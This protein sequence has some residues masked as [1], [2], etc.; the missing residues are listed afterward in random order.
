MRRFVTLAAAAALSAV[1]AACSSSSPGSGSPSGSGSAPGSGSASGSGSPATSGFTATTGTPA[2]D[3]TQLN[4]ALPGSEPAS[5]DWI[6]DWDYGPANT[7]EANLCEGLM[8]QNPDG[9]VTPALASKVESPNPTTYV[10][11]IRQGVTFT[12][13]KPMTAAD[14][15][16]SL[17]RN[18]T[19]SPPSYWGLW[20]A[21]VKSI[22]ATSSDTVTV[23]LK[24]PD[25][26][27]SEM[28]STPAGYVGEKAYIQAK[29]SAYGTSAG[30]VMCTGPYSLKNWSKGQS[31]TLARNDHYW[32]PSLQPKAATVVMSFIPDPSALNS[33]LLNGEVSGASGITVSSLAALR[34]TGSGH[35]Y[36][37]QGTETVVMQFANLTSGPLKDVRVREALRDVVDYAGI[38]KGLM[39]GYAEPAKSSTPAPTWGYAKAVFKAG[40]A[41]LAGG[42]QNLDEAKTLLQQAGAPTEP[43]VIALNSDD[44]SIINAVTAIQQAAGT[45]GLKITLKTMP[46]QEFTNLFYDAKARAAVN[47]MVNNVTAD[48][49]DPLEL[50]IQVA[51]GAPYNFTGLSNSALASD[52]AQADQATDPQKRAELTVAAGKIFSDD[53]LSIPLY[54]LDARVYLSNQVAGVPVETLTQWYYPWAAT[55]GK[56]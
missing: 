24:Q 29:G 36:V 50:L 3:L 38:T 17:S 7:I 43:I 9:T 6:Y 22:V 27:F 1:L 16:F 32:D 42:T 53:V 33:A 25:V 8:R 4:W 18:V 49:P 46:S 44:Q 40:D 19:A 41:A 45:I 35:L 39:N 30:G 31:V 55:V 51:P 47:V 26:L 52:L 37:N 13:G 23:T 28:M 21:N 10:Y 14:V 20:Y 11:T 48:V 54:S 34:N 12:D 5:L 15:A 56:A 2:G